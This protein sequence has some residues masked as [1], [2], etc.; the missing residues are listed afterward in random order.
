MTLMKAALYRGRRDVRIQTRARPEPGP[1]EVLLD[2]AYCGL[3][4]S[5]LHEY[6]DGPIFMP[7][8]PHPL[9][10]HVLPAVPGHEFAGYVRELG[11]AVDG[12]VVGQLVAVNPIVSCGECAACRGGLAHRCPQIAILGNAGGDGGL[13][14]SV[15]VDRAQVIPVPSGVSPTDAA[16]AEPLAVAVHGVSRLELSPGLRALVIG[17]GPVGI[18]A[19]L[20]LRAEGLSTIH[21]AELADQ[22][23]EV[24]QRL[25]FDLFEPTADGAGYDVVIDCAGASA[26]LAMAVDRVVSGGQILVIAMSAHEVPLS[27]TALN[28]KEV[29]IR[30][31]HLYTTRDFEIVLARF[32]SGEYTTDAWTEVVQLDDLIDEGYEA[33]RAGRR[34]KVLIA[35]GSKE[36]E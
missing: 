4:G 26:T 7:A 33:L 32:A 23:R 18:G 20:A 21:V 36:E 1:M 27:I 12:L 19:A 10:G 24:L 14:E 2:V 17:G 6:Y 31:T 3:C 34:V 28:V 25:G 30:G 35:P 15:L 16:V 13:A 11:T 8:D 29:T 22:R 9:T 5:D